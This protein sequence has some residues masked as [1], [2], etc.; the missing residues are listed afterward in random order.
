M[1]DNMNWL[2]F[3]ISERVL[4]LDG[5]YQ[6]I[7]VSLIALFYSL[8]GGLLVGFIRC[9]PNKISAF[10][11]RIYL[12]SFRII[13]LIVWLFAAFFLIPRFM[14]RGFSSEASAIWVFTLWGSAEIG[15]LVKGAIQSLPTIQRESALALGL[16]KTQL[17]MYILIPQAVRRLIPTVINMATRIIKTTSMLDFVGVIEIVARSRQII[18]RTVEPFIIWSFVFFFFF[19]LCYPLTLWSRHLEKKFR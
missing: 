1:Q 10:I 2:E 13:P 5:I 17:Y 4:L 16:S 19:F 14:G 9:I 8:I 6:T 18:E 7:Y 11:S 12:E 3:L 15:E